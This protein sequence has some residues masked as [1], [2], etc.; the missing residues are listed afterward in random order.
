MID[1][2]SDGYCVIGGMIQTG[3]RLTKVYARSRPGTGGDANIVPPVQMGAHVA[4]RWLHDKTSMS[5]IVL[6][7]L[8]GSERGPYVIRRVLLW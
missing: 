2:N 8:S 4:R 5:A 6:V 7:A 1:G 3:I